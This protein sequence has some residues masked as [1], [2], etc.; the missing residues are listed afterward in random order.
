M[1]EELKKLILLKD[2]ELR[3]IDLD[4]IMK[5]MLRRIG[6]IDPVLRD[7]MI[8]MFF[9]RLIQGE[10]LKDEQLKYILEVAMDDD[11]LF[12]R[13]EEINTDSVFTRSFSSLVM[14]LVIHVDSK[15][16]FLP[17]DLVMNAFNR[18]IEYFYEEGD[19]RGYVEEKGWAH[20]VAHGADLMEA[21]INHPKI[22]TGFYREVLEAIEQFVLRD[23]G[24]Y[25]DNEDERL[26]FPIEA[27]LKWETV[28][29][30]EWIHGLGSK[31]MKVI[32]ESRYFHLRINVS[33]FLK[34]LYFRLRF[35][36][37]TAFI[38]PHIEGILKNLYQ[39]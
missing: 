15:K 38:S 29:I 22:K 6:S 32:G 17:L 5:E 23:H 20:S 10:F 31:V 26:I 27:M 18:T 1:K 11:H 8:Y 2:N 34:T 25:I 12:Y 4:P 19:L 35:N 30:V 16:T 3:S 9:S 36:E 33:N 28:E 7:D 24:V 13:I 39:K 37:S 21:F 14:A